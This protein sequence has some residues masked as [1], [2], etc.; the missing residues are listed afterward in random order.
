MEFVNKYFGNNSHGVQERVFFL[1]QTMGNVPLICD[2]A[3]V[4]EPQIVLANTPMYEAPPP[5][6][7]LMLPAKVK[8]ISYGSFAFFLSVF[9]RPTRQ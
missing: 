2:D 8:F 1:L 3:I 9:A 6:L 7:K 5:I 4:I